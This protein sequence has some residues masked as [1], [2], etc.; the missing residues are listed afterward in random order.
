VELRVG[1]EAP[2]S[3]VVAEVPLLLLSPE[4]VVTALQLGRRV[5]DSELEQK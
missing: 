5:V 4:K 1:M 2:S 3:P